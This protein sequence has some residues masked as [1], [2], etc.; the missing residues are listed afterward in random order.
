MRSSCMAYRAILR[1]LFDAVFGSICAGC[2]A[3]GRGAA[4][5]TCRTAARRQAPIQGATFV[6]V[7]PVGRLVRAAKFGRWRGGGAWFADQLVDRLDPAVRARVVA[8]SWVP[9][10]PSRARR[11]GVDLPRDV[12]RRAAARLRVPAFDALVR[13]PRS[14]PQRGLDRSQRRTNARASFDLHPDADLRLRLLPVDRPCRE[15]V[16]LLVDDLCTTGATMAACSALLTVLVRRRFPDIHVHSI[17]MVAVP[18]P[19][20]SRGG[21]DEFAQFARKT[22]SRETLTVPIANDRDRS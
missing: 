9:R 1:L 11:R 19:D 7:R 21:V 13:R 6:D 2:G 16:V 14:R 4:C 8:V 5:C 20:R 10:A 18:P 12:A 15:P 17:A 22:H 3:R